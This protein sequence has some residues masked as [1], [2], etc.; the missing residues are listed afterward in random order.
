MDSPSRESACPVQWTHSALRPQGLLG[1]LCR[2][3]P[4]GGGVSADAPD[5]GQLLTPVLFAAAREPN[6]RAARAGGDAFLYLLRAAVA[7]GS[8]QVDVHSGCLNPL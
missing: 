4:A 6:K 3:K 2:T 1:K 7:R 5:P 8:P